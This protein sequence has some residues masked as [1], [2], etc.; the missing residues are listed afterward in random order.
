MRFAATNFNHI[1][2]FFDTYYGIRLNAEDRTLQTWNSSIDNGMSFMSD[3]IG[4]SF[5]RESLEVFED[6]WSG[7]SFYFLYSRKDLH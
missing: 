3:M 4:K 7:Q 2:N 6:Y 1:R 5:G